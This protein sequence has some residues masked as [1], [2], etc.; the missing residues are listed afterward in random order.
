M[1]AIERLFHNLKIFIEAEVLDE[2]FEVFIQE[3]PDLNSI[4]ELNQIMEDEMS[5]WG[6]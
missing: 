4:S 5:Y 2:E 6:D 3:N 1:T